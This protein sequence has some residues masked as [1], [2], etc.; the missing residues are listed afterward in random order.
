MKLFL[1]VFTA[2]Y[3]FCNLIIYIFFKI[4]YLKVTKFIKD[5][6]NILYKYLIIRFIY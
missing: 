2:N 6:N 5:N 4:K 1:F 3:I